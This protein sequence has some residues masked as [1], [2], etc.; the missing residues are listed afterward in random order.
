MKEFIILLILLALPIVSI[1]EDVEKDQG[2]CGSIYKF[3]TDCIKCHMPP[4]GDLLP[5]GVVRSG[6][7]LRLSISHISFSTLLDIIDAAKRYKISKIII[8]LFSYGGSL[9]DAMGMVA[10]IK[11]QED[12]GKIIEIRARGIIASAGLIIMVSGTKG[13]RYVDQYATVMFHEAWSFK[14]MSIETPSDKEEEAA[15]ARMIQNKVNAYITSRSKISPE[16]LLNKTRKREFWMG[17]EGAVN[18]GFADHISN[19]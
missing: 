13:H 5:S 1:A 12:L 3:K 11:E 2:I 7:V 17:A 9:F 18:Y 16:E 8:D 14:M 15:I 10:L 4:S 6:D 19:K